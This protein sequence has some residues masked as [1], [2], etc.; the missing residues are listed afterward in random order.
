M[1]RLCGRSRPDLTMDG[2]MLTQRYQ[3]Q[4][5]RELRKIRRLL[6]SFF[7]L[8]FFFTFTNGT[9]DVLRIAM[10]SV[11]VSGQ[12]TSGKVRYDLIGHFL[13]CLAYLLGRI[14]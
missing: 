6:F 11:N 10:D 2:C 12:V 4:G 13:P 3:M 5:F 14:D 8:F 9:I 1:F 7:F